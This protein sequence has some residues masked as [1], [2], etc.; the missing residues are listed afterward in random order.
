MKSVIPSGSHWG[1]YAVEVAEGR[2]QHA[3]PSPHDL[4]L[5]PQPSLDC[6]LAPQIILR[7][8]RCMSPVVAHHDRYR[9]A[10]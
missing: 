4:L 8:L 7:L 9:A 5:R 3:R 2:V 6:R 1:I 10:M